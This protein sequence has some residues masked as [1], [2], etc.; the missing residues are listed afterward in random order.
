MAK[1]STARAAGP[2]DDEVGQDLVRRL[3]ALELPTDDPGH[4][5]EAEPAGGTS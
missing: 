1:R 2:R 4:D 3:G 5:A